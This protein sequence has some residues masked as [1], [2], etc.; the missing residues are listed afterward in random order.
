MALFGKEWKM[1][2]APGRI[3]F[4]SASKPFQEPDIHLGWEIQ[5]VSIK[6]YT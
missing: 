1:A 4:F 2:I 6:F 3:L 5:S